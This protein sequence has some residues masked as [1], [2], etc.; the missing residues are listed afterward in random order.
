MMNKP[1]LGLLAGSALGLIDGLTALF[2]PAVKPYLM[3]ILI[4]ST[5]KGLIVGLAAGFFARKVR[6]VPMG[7]A[8]G[9]VCGLLFAWWVASQPTDGQYYYVEIMVPGSVVGAIVGWITQRYG[10]SEAAP[11][12]APAAQS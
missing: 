9:L 8:F 5:A 1:L 7:I 3:G 10:R 12:E 6:S 11:A 2:T 4:G